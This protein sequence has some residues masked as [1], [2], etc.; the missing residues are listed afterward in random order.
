MSLSAMQLAMA[1]RKLRVERTLLLSE[2]IAIIGIGCRF[3]G[4]VDSPETLWQLLSAGVDTVTEV[5][6]DRFDIDAFYAEPPG[7]PGKTYTR[8]GA[9]I[10][11]VDQFDASFFGISP[12]EAAQMDPQQRLLLECGWE[13]IERAAISVD[14]LRGQRTGAFVGLM[15]GDYATLIENL[16]EIDVHTPAG[17]ARCVPAGRLAH[18]LGLQGPVVGVDT[19][20]S[21]SLVALHLACGSLRA[22]ECELALA[23]GVNLIVS[24]TSTVVTSVAHMLSP[25]G[26]CK[27][28]DA[29]ADGYGRGEGCAVVALRRLSDALALGD[30]IVGLI[31]GSAVNHDGHASGLTVPNGLAQEAVVRAALDN[32][33]VEPE[34]IDYVEAHGAG[35]ALGDP[36]ELAALGRV[37]GRRPQRLLVGSLKTNIGHTEAVAGLAGLLK[38]VLAMQ[39]GRLPPHL[40]LR[41]PNPAVDW[42]NLAIE[43]PTDARPWPEHAGKR[44]AGVS[45]FGVSGTNAHVVVEQAPSTLPTSAPTEAHGTYVLP[46]SARSPTAVSALASRWSKLDA[47]LADICRSAAVGRSHL[48]WRAAIVASSLSEARSKL[49]QVAG[50]RARGRPRV[51]VHFTAHGEATGPAV[52]ALRESHPVVRAVLERCESAFHK[53]KSELGGPA[54]RLALDL[55]LFELWR[56]WG[57][58]PVA[59]VGHGPSALSAA[60]ASGSVSL[61]AAAAKLGGHASPASDAPAAVSIRR[62]ESVDELDMELPKEMERDDVFVL[63]VGPPSAS[64]EVLAQLY[65]AG[66]AIDWAQAA[67]PGRRIAL[68]TYPFERRRYWLSEAVRTRA[69]AAAQRPAGEAP[70]GDDLNGKLDDSLDDELESLESLESLVARLQALDEEEAQAMLEA[71]ES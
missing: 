61:E 12:R 63:E 21:S 16:A 27:T 23:A 56:S 10:D 71:L 14:S 36:I 8:N 45:A 44:M 55:S 19:A 5:P 52:D 1:A 67:R 60:C 69:A 31:R 2:P 4:G 20:C 17:I 3:P 65:L 29:K 32:G 24:P 66:V 43:V 53:H 70:S 41:D 25:D 64:P 7:T 15:N 40:H 54:A 59:V 28:F 51:V 42:K 30:P 68:P 46:L 22:G 34:Q 9:F 13:A 18:A 37:F 50:T 38:A 48:P 35:T 58:A 11:A 26:R 57:V 39:H 47:S 33:Q 6:A 62:L 49:M